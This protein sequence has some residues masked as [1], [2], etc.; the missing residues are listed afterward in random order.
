MRILI[1]SSILILFGCSSKTSS[2]ISHTKVNNTCLITSKPT[3]ESILFNTQ[4]NVINH[5]LSG[6]LLMKRIQ[7]DTI[8]V[9]FTNELGIKYFD[10]E[11]TQNNFRVIDCMR[12][13]KKKIIIEQLKKNFNLILMNHNNINEYQLVKTDSTKQYR[14]DGKKEQTY[15]ITDSNCSKVLRIETAN[16]E[17]KKIVIYL[18][19]EKNG[20]A[21]DIF[22]HY[23]TFR[24][25]INF[26]QIDR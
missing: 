20:I 3:F 17:K 24:F 12:K 8:R 11:F 15:Y 1:L 23:L 5:H 6:L 19:G 16:E 13:L 21:D 10:F 4:V 25:D 7:N 9:V 22:I 2:S 26:K 14:L 18:N